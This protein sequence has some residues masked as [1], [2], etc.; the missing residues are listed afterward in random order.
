MITI[1]K[2]K[3]K[4]MYYIIKVD[5][6]SVPADI[7]VLHFEAANELVVVAFAESGQNY[8]YRLVSIDDPIV[9]II[10]DP[11]TQLS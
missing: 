11:M 9:L 7:E 3:K 8:E 1:I 6:F 4:I 5:M 10:P 2:Q